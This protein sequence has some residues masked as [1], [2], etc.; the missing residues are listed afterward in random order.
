[1]ASSDPRRVL[2]WDIQKKL[3][4][5]TEQQLY[6]LAVALEDERE[7]AIP[8]ATG[9]NE[10][11]LFDHIV[12][13]MNSESLQSREDKGM[14]CLLVLN[15]KIDELRVTT[16]DTPARDTGGSSEGKRV[17][18]P[19]VDQVAE[20][21]RL[22][23][24]AALLPRREF[25]LHGGFISDSGSD[26][27]YSNICKQVDDGLK[28]KFPESEIIRTVLKLTKPGS[29]K[30]MLTNKEDLTVDE[31]K[32]FLRSHLRDKASTELFQE[33]SNARQQDKETPQQFMYRIMGLKQ[34]VLFASQQ[35]DADFTYDK[36]L[37]QGVFLHTLYQGLNEKSSNVRRDIKPYISDLTATDDFILEQI[38]KAAAEDAE[39]QIRLASASKPKH[40]TASVSQ[41]HDSQSDVQ[42]CQRD[43]DTELQASR[44]AIREL[45]AQVS[46]LTKNV[47]KILSPD[48]AMANN[49]SSLPPT[50]RKIAQKNESKGKCSSCIEQGNERC[51]HCF[52]CGQEGHRA[53]GCLKKGSRSGNGQRPLARDTQ[54]PKQA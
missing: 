13:Y 5:L 46:A 15:D 21:V 2:Q 32:R 25:K 44:S 29:F 16:T 34:R 38:T 31:L 8:A 54:W 9:S 7:V 27:S 47:E 40:P 45:T 51:T 43:V 37:V 49:Q 35:G 24:I 1:M 14:A 22:N 53:V 20:L 50:N 42:T 19:V 39:R 26:M 30:D 23:D 41:L 17:E 33:L 10:L 3:H 12:G 48:R 36:K 52:Y 18:P 28:E 6:R 11:E 4:H